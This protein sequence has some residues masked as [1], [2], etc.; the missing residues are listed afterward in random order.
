M[1]TAVLRIRGRS[2]AARKLPTAR[3][4]CLAGRRS[5]AGMSP[6]RPCRR[7]GH[8]VAQTVACPPAATC[9]R[10]TRVTMPTPTAFELGKAGAEEVLARYLQEHGDWPTSLVFGLWGSQS[11]RTAARKLRRASHSWAAARSG[12]MPPGA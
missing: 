2:R 3:T 10:P 9:S 4:L 7:A 11:L 1:S 6:A 12:I 5:T 8:A